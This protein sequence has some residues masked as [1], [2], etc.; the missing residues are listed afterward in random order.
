MGISRNVYHCLRTG[1][2]LIAWPG[3][4]FPGSSGVFTFFPGVQIKMEPSPRPPTL[5]EM[6]S[7]SAYLRGRGLG[8]AAP[9][10]RNFFFGG[11]RLGLVDQVGSLR[12]VDRVSPR[13]SPS[14][15]VGSGD[16]ALLKKLFAQ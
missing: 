2:W 10:H 5:Y 8:C 15:V 4:G 12:I 14:V 13:W 7:F 6:Q 11:S 9:G 1:I 3:S 16:A